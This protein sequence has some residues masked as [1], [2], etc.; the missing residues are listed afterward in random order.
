VI[1]DRK[2]A[3]ESAK[4]GGLGVE[5]LIRGETRF[6]V[7]REAEEGP[8]MK[9]GGV[10]GKRRF[11][12]RGSTVDN[13]T[14]IIVHS[15]ADAINNGNTTSFNLNT[16]KYGSVRA[17]RHSQRLLDQSEDEHDMEVDAISLPSRP[18]IG[19]NFADTLDAAADDQEDATT[20]DVEMEML[21]VLE[22]DRTLDNMEDSRDSGRKRV[23][24]E[25]R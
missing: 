8:G 3:V 21:D 23:F 24:F 25:D 19:F 16:G 12:D 14:A 6:V 10:I 20:R 11:L 9:I 17:S 4:D 18:R 2:K 22:I 15:R 5:I 1:S 7:I 13:T